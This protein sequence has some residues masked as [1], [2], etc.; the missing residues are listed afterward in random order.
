M[1]AA[2]R[3]ALAG[4]HTPAAARHR[5]LAAVLRN[6]AVWGE[7]AESVSL[8]L[9]ACTHEQIVSCCTCGMRSESAKDTGTTDV[10]RAV[11]LP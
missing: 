3:S 2:P 5:G 1:V 11:G 6:P 7:V 10:L 9:G 4:G 8:K